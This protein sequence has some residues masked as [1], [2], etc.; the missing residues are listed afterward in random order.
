M[1]A[2]AKITRFR[3]YK[4]NSAGSSFSYFNGSKFTLV[5]ARYSDDNKISIKQ[6]MQ[7][8]SVDTINIVHITSWDQDHCVPSQLKDI[9][10]KFSPGKIEY[11]GYEPH[12][13]SGKECLKIINAHNAQKTNK[14]K[15]V[16]LTPEYIKSLDPAQNYGYKDI[17]YHPKSID[18]EIPNNNSCIMQFRSGSFNVLSLGDVESTN[19]AA[20]LRRLR[21]VHREVDIMI[22][23]HHGANNGFTTSKFLQQ[24]RPAL[25]IACANYA[26]Q[27]NHP[28]PEIRQLL[29]K[30]QIKLFTTK[31]GDVIV[32]STGDHKTK[33]RAVSLQTDSKKVSEQL[34]FN[35]K[36][37]IILNQHTDN[38][39]ARLNP[40]NKGPKRH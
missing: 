7:L 4:L 11:P 25:A 15:F 36:K 28:K 10:S 9:I 29:I 21:T 6:E 37:G 2:R 19:I 27:F 32:Y 30:H 14:I 24:T 40:I 34:D 33:Y 31:T 35:S 16:R 18:T 39:R 8:C 12:S 26:N 20:G 38:L 3:A 17:I 13:D 1:V 5:E 22:L 23:A